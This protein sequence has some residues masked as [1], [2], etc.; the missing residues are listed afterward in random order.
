MQALQTTMCSAVPILYASRWESLLRSHTQK[1]S[2]PEQLP[3]FESLEQQ[4]YCVSRFQSSRQDLTQRG[5]AVAAAS[6]ALSLTDSKV[7]LQRSTSAILKG[8]YYEAQVCR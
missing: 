4:S 3:S 7:L 8:Q 2:W 1:S 5:Y 6:M